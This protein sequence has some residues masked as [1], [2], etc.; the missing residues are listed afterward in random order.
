MVETETET[1]RENVC[2]QLFLGCSFSLYRF[3]AFFLSF[4]NSHYLL[5]FLMFVCLYLYLFGGSAAA[6]VFVLC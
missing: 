3:L 4:S 2:I 5:T 1:E 6:V